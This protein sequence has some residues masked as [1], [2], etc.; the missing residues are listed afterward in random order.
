MVITI[1]DSDHLSHQLGHT[2]NPTDFSP[3]PGPIAT[4]MKPGV[5]RI[6]PNAQERGPL[7]LDDGMGCGQKQR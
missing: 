1:S 5:S 2:E 6:G 4:S 3:R 7:P